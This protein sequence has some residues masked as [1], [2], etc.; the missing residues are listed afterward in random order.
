[1]NAIVDPTSPSPW[2]RPT[3]CRRGRGSA[4]SPRPTRYNCA[5]PPSQG[6]HCGDWTRLQGT[7]FIEKYFETI[8]DFQ[9]RGLGG[10]HV[11]IGVGSRRQRLIGNKRLGYVRRFDD[12]CEYVLQ[13]TIQEQESPELY[14]NLP[15]TDTLFPHYLKPLI[16]QYGK[17][18]LIKHLIHFQTKV[19]R[20]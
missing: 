5:T 19:I 3:R 17:T 15:G 18:I 14:T 20:N 16:P 7:E 12:Y 1:M 2:C 10:R 8:A 13:K 4:T 9:S 6:R 11:Q